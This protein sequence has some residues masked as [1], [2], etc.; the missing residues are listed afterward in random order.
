MVH[1]IKFNNE[2]EKEKEEKKFGRVNQ[3]LGIHLAPFLTHFVSGFY[4]HEYFFLY[5]LCCLHKMLKVSH[6]PPAR[7]GYD[8]CVCATC[9]L[10]DEGS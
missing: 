9:V 3:K 1:E 8:Y 2:K 10:L 7:P 5:V 6:W 4:E